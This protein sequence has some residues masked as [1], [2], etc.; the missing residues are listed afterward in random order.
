MN[1]ATMQMEP[2]EARRLYIE[3][4]K[5]LRVRRDERRKLAEIEE[6]EARCKRMQ[7]EREEDDLR[8]AYRAMSLNQRVVVLPHAIVAAGFDEQGLPK[9]AVARA[10][11]EWCHYRS[12]QSKLRFQKTDWT[13][14]EMMSFETELPEA[15]QAKWRSHRALVPPIPPRFRPKS[16]EG[17][18]ILWEADWQRVP[19]D[20]IL[21]KQVTSRVFVVLAQ[22]DL[23]PVE[24]AVLEGRF[25]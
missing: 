22:W 10:E 4:R 1:V 17:Y 25:A 18:C 14:S 23:T 5:S 15:A 20:P 11:W 8:A 16:L 24:R 7:I 19:E 3:Y 21:L 9:L 12:E 13:G 6:I 2:H